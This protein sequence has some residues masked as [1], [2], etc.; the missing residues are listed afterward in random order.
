MAYDENGNINQWYY[1]MSDLGYNY[2]ITDIQSAL[3]NS[4]LKKIDKFI[5]ARRKIAKAA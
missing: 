3:G 4:Q 2:R 1:E 5:K